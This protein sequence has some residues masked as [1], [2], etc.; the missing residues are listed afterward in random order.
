MANYEITDTEV[1][2][3]GAKHSQIV[4]PHT[5]IN[6]TIPE[7]AAWCENPG[8]GETYY[9]FNTEVDGGAKI[10]IQVY[11]AEPGDAGNFKLLVREKQ[12]PKKKGGFKFIY[13]KLIATDEP[14][15]AEAEI[16]SG[17]YLRSLMTWRNHDR[18]TLIECPQ[19]KH[20]GA[21]VIA[22]FGIDLPEDEKTL[23]VQRSRSKT[24]WTTVRRSSTGRKKSA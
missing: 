5:V 1:H 4:H 19:Q 6:I 22:P 17:A 23:V 16:K 18:I 3:N 14:A 24:R 2:E 8:T 9:T 20:F 13:C 21:V 12:L 15:N 7:E 11:G 10:L